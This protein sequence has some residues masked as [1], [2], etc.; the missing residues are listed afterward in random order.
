MQQ[1]DHAGLGKYIGQGRLS[2][3]SFPRAL[4]RSFSVASCVSR[5]LRFRLDTHDMCVYIYIYIYI[6]IYRER[7]I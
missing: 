7:E 6:Y 1:T 2:S 5:V 3:F 4:S